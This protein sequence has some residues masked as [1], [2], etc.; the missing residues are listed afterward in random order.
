[1]RVGNRRG[2]GGCVGDRDVPAAG[3]AAGGVVGAHLRQIGGR[4]RDAG[5]LL[6]FAGGGRT[7]LPAIHVTA[8]RSR[9]VRRFLAGALQ[10]LVREWF[11]GSYEYGGFAAEGVLGS[12]AS[13]PTAVA[14]HGRPLRTPWPT[15]PRGMKRAVLA[16][17]RLRSPTA[18][19]G[20]DVALPAACGAVQ[21]LEARV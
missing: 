1:M 3:I 13:E 14:D 16:V 2:Q 10:E 18:T 17:R 5:L 21:I 9:R 15:T 7:R 19:A 11:T 4:D 6:E 8:R 12:W 20:I